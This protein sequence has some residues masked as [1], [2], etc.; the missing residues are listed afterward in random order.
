M[1]KT[2]HGVETAYNIPRRHFNPVWRRLS[3]WVAL[4]FCIFGRFQLR[5]QPLRSSLFVADASMT[6][7]SALM[8]AVGAL[9]TVII[10]QYRENRKKEDAAT[11]MAVDAATAI[12]EATRTMKGVVDAMARLTDKIARCPI[13]PNVDTRFDPGDSR[14]R[15]AQRSLPQLLKDP[16]QS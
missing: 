1:K 11:R 7:D 15:P 16:G 9:S 5:A 13:N 4:L 6:L 2:A 3:P 10:V 8:V 14:S 12:S